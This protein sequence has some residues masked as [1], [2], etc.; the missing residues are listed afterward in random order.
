MT[1]LSLQTW[2]LILLLLAC[3]CWALAARAA[4]GDLQPGCVPAY[5]VMDP[6]VSQV[7]SWQ[8]QVVIRETSRAV[9]YRRD[10]VATDRR[11]CRLLLNAIRDVVLRLP[12]VDGLVQLDDDCR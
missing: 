9:R 8:F 4:L 6:D 5:A 12:E 1:R 11:C 3:L 10:F 2:A 7:K